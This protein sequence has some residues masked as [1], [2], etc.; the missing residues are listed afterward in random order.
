MILQTSRKDIVINDSM[1]S[2]LFIKKHSDFIA[3]YGEDKDEYV[4]NF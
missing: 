1:P 3:K 4:S 2:K